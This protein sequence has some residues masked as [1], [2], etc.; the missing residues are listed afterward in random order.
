MTSLNLVSCVTFSLWE[1][2]MVTFA[3]FWKGSGSRWSAI[4]IF[5]NLPN[6]PSQTESWA[7]GSGN[8]SDCP[9][10]LLWLPYFLTILGELKETG[11]G[12][13]TSSLSCA[14]SIGPKHK[15][16]WSTRSTSYYVE[17]GFLKNCNH[18]SSIA[19]LSR[20]TSQKLNI[21]SFFF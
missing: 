2:W 17:E 1:Q 6:I 20:F 11:F 21:N 14:S 5:L 3:T 15:E 8:I 19:W 18:F 10:L 7:W 13:F 9:F 16:N 4:S 12:F